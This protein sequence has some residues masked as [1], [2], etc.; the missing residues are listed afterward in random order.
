MGFL[1]SDAVDKTANYAQRGRKYG[2][3]SPD[4]LRQAWIAAFKG[5][6][7]D[8]SDKASYDA[9]NDLEAETSLR[10]IKPP[11]DQVQ[12]ELEQ[13]ISTA[14]ARFETLKEHPDSLKAANAGLLLDFEK[15][16]AGKAKGS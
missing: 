15:Y 9:Q 2:G 16:T 13:Y 3:L 5:M 8:P 6:A 12:A 1:Q 4:D 11:Y 7:A 10:G 14:F